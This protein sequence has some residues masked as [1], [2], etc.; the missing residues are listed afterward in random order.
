MNKLV[1][2]VLAALIALPVFSQTQPADNASAEEWM[3]YFQQREAKA[4][5]EKERIQN[6]INATDSEIQ[7]IKQDTANIR[8]YTAEEKQML[9]DFDKVPKNYVVKSGDWLSKLAEYPEV[10][11]KGNYWKWPVIYRA[12]RDQ[13]KNYDLIYPGQDFVVP[14]LLPTE[15]KVYSGETVSGIA[16]YYEIY[17]KDGSKRA[18]E[19]KDANTDKV[20]NPNA[21]Q[22]GIILSIPRP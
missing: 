6:E 3:R 18:N 12:N 15:W 13:I 1:L 11:G 19:I 22:P 2:L 7:K 10:Y 14:R 16:S 9:E 4:K 21:L 5:V 8:Q 17:Y 20:T